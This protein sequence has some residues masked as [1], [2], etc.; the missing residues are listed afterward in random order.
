M[1]VEVRTKV[2]R[3]SCGRW[4]LPL[5]LINYFKYTKRTITHLPS[6]FLWEVGLFEGCGRVFHR[7]G[8]LTM[9]LGNSGVVF[10]MV[11]EPRAD[12][13]SLL[14]CRNW[15]R[16]LGSYRDRRTAALEAALKRTTRE[17][18]SSRAVRHLG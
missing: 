7:R 5:F 15:S 16:D 14:W 18:G 3:P 9:F 6:I 17:R 10:L 12:Q 1:S 8:D 13:D 4:A 11:E 2:Q